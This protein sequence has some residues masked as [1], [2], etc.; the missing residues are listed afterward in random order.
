MSPGWG[1]DLELKRLVAARGGLPR[2]TD[3]QTPTCQQEFDEIILTH[4]FKPRKRLN[5]TAPLEA[6]YQN[7]NLKDK[8]QKR[9][10][11]IYIFL[12]S[13]IMPSKTYDC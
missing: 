6:F 13:L 9:V 4:I 7:L 2:K 8:S 5:W 3:L 11:L 10:G 12:N 1:G